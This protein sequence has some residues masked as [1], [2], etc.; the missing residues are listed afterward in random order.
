VFVSCF[1]RSTA[2]QPFAC[3]HVNPVTLEIPVRGLVHELE[4][5]LPLRSVSGGQVSNRPREQRPPRA[6]RPSRKPVG[7]G[8]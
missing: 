5:V 8:S 2:L 3:S 7:R 6:F 4:F 1:G